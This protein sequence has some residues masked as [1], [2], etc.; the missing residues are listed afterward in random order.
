M[1]SAKFSRPSFRA[2]GLPSGNITVVGGPQLAAKFKGM[3]SYVGLRL[4]HA[5]YELAVITQTQAIQHAPVDTGNL[6]TSIWPEKDGP[7]SWS[8]IADTREGADPAGVGKNDYEYANFVEYG[9][10]K[11]P[12]KPF[13]RPAFAYA[14]KVAPLKM[15]QLGKELETRF[16]TSAL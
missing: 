1:A 12:A 10:S 8:V 7:Y 11:M 4:G 2:G 15:Q 6:Q 14:A 13:M 16:R 3:G 5:T 9:T